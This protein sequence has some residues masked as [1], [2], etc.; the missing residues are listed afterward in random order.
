MSALA[1]VVAALAC[2]R[3]SRALALEDGPA[4]AF[5]LARGWVCGRV[6]NAGWL[7]EGVCCAL[8]LSFWLGWLVALALPWQGWVSYALTSLALSGATVVLHR[9]VG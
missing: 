3:L 6:G 8:C 5:L 4:R 7:C 9:R 1:F 2:Y